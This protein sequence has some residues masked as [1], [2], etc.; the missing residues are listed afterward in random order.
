MQKTDDSILEVCFVIRSYGKG[1]LAMCYIRGVAQQTAVNRFN[2]WIRKA[3]GLEQRLQETGL[4]RTDRCY[5]PAQVPL[6]M[7][8]PEAKVVG[9]RDLSPDVNGNGEVEPMEWTKECPCFK[10]EKERW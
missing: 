8:Y 6:K 10:V 2:T 3:P 5:T 4:S 7:D 1:E 9:H